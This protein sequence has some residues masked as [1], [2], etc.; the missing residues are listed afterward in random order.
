MKTKRILV[1]NQKINVEGWEI[2]LMIL[3]ILSILGPEELD[4]RDD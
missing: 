4:N 2:I 3:L 1:K